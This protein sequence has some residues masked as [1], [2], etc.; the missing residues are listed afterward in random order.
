M[1]KRVRCV[2][3]AIACLMPPLLPAAVRAQVSNHA[4]RF[5][6][7]GVNQQDRAR[8]LIDDNAPGPDASAPC[9]VGA[10]SFTV[11]FWLR[12][13]LADNST[14]SAGGDLELPG[15]GWIYGNIVVD[16]D[17]WGDSNRDWGISLAGGLVRFGTG[18]G[19]G[20]DDPESTLE[21]G[22][23]VLD[24]QWHHVAC[25]RDTATGRKSIYVD[26]TLD[27][28]TV[29]LFSDDDISFPNGG[30][31][32]PVTPW[33]PYLVIGAEK[34]DAD[35]G[36]FPS[37]AGYFDELRIWSVA[38]PPAELQVTYNRVTPAASPGLVGYYR[39][40]EGSGSTAVD[41]SAAGSPDA[42]VIAGAPGNGEW[43]AR[44]TNP[45]NTA[46]LVSGPGVAIPTV[47]YWGALVMLLTLLVIGTAAF[48]ERACQLE[49]CAFASAMLGRD[50][51]EAESAEDRRL[52]NAHTGLSRVR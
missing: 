8:I 51:K 21:G 36:Q 1:G 19:D 23:N 30:V 9:D 45:N 11:E 42:E 2:A 22:V 37:F 6:G 13:N 49:V 32:N 43:V 48:R 31:A 38:R 25:V 3:V 52:R 33:N 20:G 29:N 12:G 16:R 15:V 40:E 28:A 17:I 35:V 39:F 14:A 4:L 18:S 41:T 44:A 46:P 47:S 7:T 34:H 5:Y 26:T 10:G 50:G 24:G 27:F